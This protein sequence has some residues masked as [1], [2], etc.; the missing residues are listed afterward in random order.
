VSAGGRQSREYPG[1]NAE[2][3]GQLFPLTSAS[4][5]INIDSQGTSG[6]WIENIDGVLIKNFDSIDQAK[7]YNQHAEQYRVIQNIKNG[8][9]SCS[10]N[11][12]FNC[13]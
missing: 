12:T 4:T 13:P 7:G 8:Y 1:H 11:V 5:V 10:V 9:N 2:I 6:F 3:N